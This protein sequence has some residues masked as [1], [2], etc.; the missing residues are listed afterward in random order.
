MTSSSGYGG[1]RYAPYAFPEQGVAML[2]S[3]FNSPRDIAISIEINI[4]IMRAF[5]QARSMA[6]THQDL[7]RQL[8]E[9]QDKTELLP[10]SSC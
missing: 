2:S 5:V 1:P 8:T 10:T 6:A 7:A 4:E 3:V 9:L